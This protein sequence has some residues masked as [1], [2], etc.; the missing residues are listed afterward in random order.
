ML[1]RIQKYIMIS[2]PGCWVYSLA[3]IA[4]NSPMLKQFLLKCVYYWTRIKFLPDELIQRPVLKQYHHHIQWYIK[5]NLTSKFCYPNNCHR[6]VLK[7][8]KLFYFFIFYLV[9]LYSISIYLHN[10]SK[11]QVQSVCIHNYNQQIHWY[12]TPCKFNTL[13]KAIRKWTTFIKQSTLF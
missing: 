7:E 4:A 12:P 6:R 13:I 2:C 1:E 3:L 10:S 5:M 9:S 8:I 11:R